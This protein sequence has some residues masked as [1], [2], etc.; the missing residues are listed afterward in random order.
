[1]FAWW[2]RQVAA[3]NRTVTPLETID[4]QLNLYRRQA[5]HAATELDYERTRTAWTRIDQL[6]DTRSRLMLEA[7][8]RQ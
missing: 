8:Y 6:L 1:M 7:A 5:A 4:E 3:E 2:T